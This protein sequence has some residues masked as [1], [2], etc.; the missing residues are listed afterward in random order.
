MYSRSSL[1]LTFDSVII[2][3][4]GVGLQIYSAWSGELFEYVG[5]CL[6]PNLEAFYFF[7]SVGWAR[8]LTP[9][10]PALWKA[11]V[12][13]SRGQEIETILANTVKPHLC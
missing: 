12:G 11:K 1:S 8:W 6:S 3:C 10:I 7:K 13:R 2:M 5:S 9:V 4:L